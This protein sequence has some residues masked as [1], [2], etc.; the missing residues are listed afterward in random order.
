MQ[1]SGFPFDGDITDL[2]LRSLPDFQTLKCT[3]L[4]CKSFLLIFEAHPKAIVQSVAH[5]VTGA[6]LPFALAAAQSKEDISWEGPDNVKVDVNTVISRSMVEELERNAEATRGLENLFSWRYDLVAW[7]KIEIV[8][9]TADSVDTR[10][11]HP[12]LANSLMLSL[13]GFNA[14]STAFPIFQCCSKIVNVSKATPNT[15]CLNILI[16]N[17]SN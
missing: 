14:L 2:I 1:R 6:I 4:T 5:N 15:F 17:Y 9:N 7:S 12:G 3:I 10:T 16:K 13:G 11:E 8:L